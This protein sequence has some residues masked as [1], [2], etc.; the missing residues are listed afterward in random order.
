MANEERERVREKEREQLSSFFAMR[1][2]S[3]YMTP[4][5]VF[6]LLLNQVQSMSPSKLRLMTPR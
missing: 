4:W 5:G 1:H 2:F 6:G 3:C